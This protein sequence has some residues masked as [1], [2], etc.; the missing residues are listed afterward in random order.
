M[1][2]HRWALEHSLGRPLAADESALHRC[3][4]PPCV[5]PL[6][7]YAGTQADNMQDCTR[8]GRLVNPIAEAKRAQTHCAKGHE[9]TPENTYIKS[10]GHRQCRTCRAAGWGDRR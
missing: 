6:H 1:Y 9:F 3:D 5:N 7:L 10:S 8:R 2:A 4:N